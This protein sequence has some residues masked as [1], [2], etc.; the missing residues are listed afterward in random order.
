MGGA[1]DTA[2]PS[3][4]EGKMLMNVHYLEIVTA[5][6]DATCAMYSQQ[7]GAHFSDPVAEL[8][9]ARLATL[10]SGGLIGVRSPIC[11]NPKSQ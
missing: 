4:R 7:H 6:D 3:K 1:G 11:T 2:R 9:N 10:A 5:S 8:G